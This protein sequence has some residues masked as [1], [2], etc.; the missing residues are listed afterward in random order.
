M[1]FEALPAFVVKKNVVG[2][3]PLTPPGEPILRLSTRPAAPGS[4]T[5]PDHPLIDHTPNLLGHH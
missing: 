3:L 1:S 5:E 4:S 2:S